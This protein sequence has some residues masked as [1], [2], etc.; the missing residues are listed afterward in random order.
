MSL[1]VHELSFKSKKCEIIT[2]IFQKII[3]DLGL[4]PNKICVNKDN[5]FCNKSM[6]SWLKDNGI[7]ICSTNNERKSVVPD[8][9][10][11]LYG[12]YISNG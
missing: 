8:Q 1:H 5:Y 11:K 4:K 10:M 12:S 6:K 7:K 2:T 9:F 3:K